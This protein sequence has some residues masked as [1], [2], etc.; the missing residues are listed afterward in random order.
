MLSL[1]SNFLLLLF[2]HTLIGLWVE[3]PKVE[4]ML[5]GIPAFA[6]L[7][8]SVFLF[9][10]LIQEHLTSRPIIAGQGFLNFSRIKST[11]TSSHL[12]KG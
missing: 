6:F 5:L 10:L 1:L 12:S 7:E 3:L 11:T 8:T 4:I 2:L 9:Y